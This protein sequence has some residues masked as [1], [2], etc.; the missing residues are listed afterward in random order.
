L[1]VR[2]DPEALKVGR[3]QPQTYD[4][5]RVDPI[6]EA[7]RAAGVLIGNGVSRPREVDRTQQQLR[8]QQRIQQITREL[9]VERVK[10]TREATQEYRRGLRQI[11]NIGEKHRLTQELQQKLGQ[12][13][14]TYRLK[15]LQAGTGIT[16][17]TLTSGE[18]V[19][20]QATAK[21]LLK[22]YEG[23]GHELTQEQIRKLEQKGLIIPE[24]KVVEKGDRKSVV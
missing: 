19:R 9:N 20:S 14:D 21:D 7:A 4:P 11:K 18:Q 12:I 8:D 16:A 5:S 2:L 1:A 22:V 24:K 3:L 23:R 13:Q 10:L 6:R 15:K 17:V